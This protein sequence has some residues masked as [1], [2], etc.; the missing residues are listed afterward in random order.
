MS[1][2]YGVKKPI[3]TD[4]SAL[5]PAGSRVA[6]TGPL[7]AGS[8]TIL[9]FLFGLQKPT[10]GQILVN[11]V[12]LRQWDLRNFRA[13][14]ALLRSE[15]I[16]EGTVLENILVGRE[17][18]DLKAVNEALERV[19]L[20]DRIAQLED[21]L[22]THLEAG[23]STLSYSSRVLLVLARVLVDPPAL[24][25]VDRFLKE[26][27]TDLRARIV[28]ELFD[29]SRPWTLFLAT[30]DKELANQCD[31]VVELEYGGGWTIKRNEKAPM[32]DGI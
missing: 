25:I 32:G 3:L 29:R 14:A 2:S 11:S 22:N 24:L 30:W 5:F 8:T 26:L 28:N 17:H 6:I 23:A 20:I 15:E 7:G 13:A 31:I 12:D 27:D 18:I 16:V 19:N 1:F 10:S 21:G 4:F 9:N